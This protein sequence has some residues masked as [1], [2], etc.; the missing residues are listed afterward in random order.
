MA[1]EHGLICTNGR[2]GGEEEMTVVIY[3]ERLMI[4]YHSARVSR[5]HT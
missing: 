4:S 1:E 3:H 5:A 2:K